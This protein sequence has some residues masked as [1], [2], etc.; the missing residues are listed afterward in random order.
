M[1]GND[2]YQNQPGEP[3][4]GQPQPTPPQQGQPSPSGPQY[5]GPGYPG[6]GYGQ[7][8]QGQGGSYPP[9]YGQASPPPYGQQGPQP[10]GQQ[11][12]Q[13]PGGP[14]PYGQQGPGGPQQYGMYPP[15]QPP[16][17][18][19][20]GPK[21]AIIIGAGVLALV[22]IGTVIG[23]G[24]AGSKDK[25]STSDPNQAPAPAPAAKP[26]DAVQGYLQAL[27]NGDAQTALSYAS[28]QPADTTFLT[29]QVL[30]ASNKLAPIAN[31]TVPAVDDEYAYSVDASYTRGGKKVNTSIS[32]QKDGDSWKLRDVAYDLDLGSRL[33]KSL[34]MIVNGVQV[35][36]DTIALFPGSYEFT[37]GNKNISYGKADVIALNSPSEYPRGLYNLQPT[38]TS[39]GKKTFTNALKASIKACMK[40][41]NLKNPG[42]PNNVTRITTAGVTGKNGTFKWS[43]Q[44]D[45]LDNLKPRLV[46]D[47]PAKATASVYLRMKAQGTCKKGGSQGSCTITPLSSATPTAKLTADKVTV[48]WTY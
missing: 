25:T 4:S 47:N 33:N 32:V 5:G 38:L 35:K 26:S 45:S 40:K 8:N 6:P 10:Y 37:T 31:I 30:A 29:N 27:A 34:P 36:S 23:L 46:Y 17:P 13:G 16:Q 44:K 18:K 11:G 28:T 24:V 43:W 41:K 14:Q 15:G 42:C 48:V 22:L 21:L 1:S 39:T 19:K 7:P 20:K 12:P 3:Q 9:P 2:P